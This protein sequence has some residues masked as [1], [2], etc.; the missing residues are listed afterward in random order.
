MEAKFKLEQRVKL[1]DKRE[2]DWYKSWYKK[3]YFIIVEIFYD[4]HKEGYY[5]NHYQNMFD[6]TEPVYLLNMGVDCLI[7]VDESEISEI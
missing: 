2:N 6:K 5:P 4:D 7:A 1:K 3:D